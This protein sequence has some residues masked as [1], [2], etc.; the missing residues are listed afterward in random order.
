M[1]TTTCPRRRRWF[2]GPHGTVR[3]GCRAPRRGGGHRPRGDGE[4]PLR[5]VPRRDGR[6]AGRGG[7]GRVR[8]AGADRGPVGRRA[9]RAGRAA[10]GR[11]RPVRRL[12]G[13]RR[14]DRGQPGADAGH[15]DRHRVPGRGRG[16]G[17][18]QRRGEGGRGRARPVVPA[19]PV[20]V[21][22]LLDR[23]QRRH[24]RGRAVLRE[25]R[26]DHRLRPRPRRGARRRH[27]GDPRREADQGRRR[28]LAAQAV[29]RQRGHPRHRH[30]G[31]P[32]AGAG[33]GRPLD[34]GGVVPDGGRGRRCR[35][36]GG[37]H[38]AA[39]R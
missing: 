22:D 28:A 5:L 26:R 12:V 7:A 32:A 29:R 25:V 10:R 35:G 34:R 31:D 18:V 17:C 2:H 9:P 4:V 16:A 8:R 19:R 27:P 6:E 20:V 13:R 39:R 1:R 14:R 37:P 33:P 15:R 24:Q 11:Q 38:P 23:R 36:R 30:P 21:R 3:P